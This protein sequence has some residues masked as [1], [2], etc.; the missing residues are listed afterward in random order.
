MLVSSGQDA[1]A[2]E[3]RP[4]D[5]FHYGARLSCCSF[6]WLY[7]AVFSAAVILLEGNFHYPI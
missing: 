6:L 7:L 5:P 4:I 3:D 1:R 2:A